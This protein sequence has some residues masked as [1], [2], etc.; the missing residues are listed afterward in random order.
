MLPLYTGNLPQM[1]A[2]VFKGGAADQLVPFWFQN[3]SY[4]IGY[5]LPHVGLAYM[6]VGQSHQWEPES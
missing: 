4:W 6:T 5:K 2:Q 3:N 1:D